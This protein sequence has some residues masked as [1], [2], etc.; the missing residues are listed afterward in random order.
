MKKIFDYFLPN[1]SESGE[2]LTP[3]EIAKQIRDIELNAIDY[4]A[5]G[6]EYE[7]PNQLDRKATK[8]P[9]L[10]QYSRPVLNHL[11]TLRGI[12]SSPREFQIVDSPNLSW[13]D[14]NPDGDVI[15]RKEGPNHVY[16]FAHHLTSPYLN[17]WSAGL[18]NL[19]RG[20]PFLGLAILE[21]NDKM[22]G[23]W[24]SSYNYSDHDETS[25]DSISMS[26]LYPEREMA[27]QFW[28]SPKRLSAKSLFEN[29]PSS[30]NLR[31]H[32]S[33]VGEKM[34]GD[35]RHVILNFDGKRMAD[36]EEREHMWRDDLTERYVDLLRK[37]GNFDFSVVEIGKTQ[38]GGE[39]HWV[40]TGS[41][42]SRVEEKSSDRVRSAVTK[43]SWQ[44]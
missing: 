8:L 36:F 29:F 14:E 5:R 37:R 2:S 11:Q 40:Y 7:I 24:Q 41:D 4:G 27:L 31:D 39:K 33:L 26:H 3:H 13:R 32:L 19:A 30:K 10:L 22:K 34:S 16:Y 25:D 17:S 15:Y 44:H 9:T 43:L 20:E 18:D 35:F 28:F 42:I 21:N 23:L 12:L 6:S 38:L 1:N